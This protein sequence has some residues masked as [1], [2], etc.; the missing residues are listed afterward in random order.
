MRIGR[1]IKQSRRGLC[2]AALACGVGVPGLAA[3]QSDTNLMIGVTNLTPHLDP[4]GIMANV[5]WRISQ[6]HLETLIR[7]DYQTGEL[8]PGLATSWKR[9]SP[10]VLELALR[11]GV[12]CHNG[13]PFNAEDVEIMFGP[14][15]FQGEGAPGY[16][17]ARGQLGIVKSVEALTPHTVRFE[18]SGPDPLFE[19]RLANYMSEVPCADAYRAVGDWDKWGQAVVGTGPYMLAEARPGELQR[20]ERFDGYWGAKAPV[21]S[22]TLKVVPETGA[23]IA[24][25]L[26]GEYQIVTEISPDQFET[27]SNNPKTEVVGGAIQNIRSLIYDTRH[28]ALSDPRI[29]RA[30]SLAIDRKLIVD[31]IF[32][33]KTSISNG[34][35]MKAFGDM[36]I[37]DFEPTTYDPDLARQLMKEAGYNGEEIPYWYLTDYY[38]GEVTIAQ[39]LQQMWKDVG[40]NI[41]LQLKESWAQIQAEKD[42]GVRGITNTSNNAVYPDPIGQLYRNYGPDGHFVVKEY[43]SNAAFKD[44]GEGL[45]S[46]DHETRRAAHLKM[47]EIWKQDPPGTHLYNLPMFYGKAASVDWTPTNTPFMDFRAKSLSVSLN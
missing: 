27:I 2:L 20:F 11:E 28:P 32:H 36:Y 14:E 23:R 26:A 3:A 46:L 29:R 17:E 41:T 15:R 34:F 44:A 24:G 45:L 37:E 30:L 39:V 35:Q 33:G 22:F 19:L 4:M 38:T 13:E 1:H 40:F 18:T 5:N 42:N 43:W 12:T 16:L 8:K 6:N 25:L 10:T 21:A 9:V 31:S 7:Y 47:L